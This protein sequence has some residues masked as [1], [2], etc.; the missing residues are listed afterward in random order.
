MNADRLLAL[1][2]RVAE[3]PDAIARLRRFVL[4]LAVRGKLVKQDPADEPASELLKR[5]E[6]EK[7][8]LVQAGKIRKSPPLVPIDHAEQPFAVPNSWEWVSSTYPTLGVSDLGKK[9]KT[10][11][12]LDSG[13]FP[14]VDQG[15]V[16]VRGYC[17]DPSRVIAVS[18]PVVVFGDHTREAKLIDFDFVVGADGVKI[19]QP[20]CVDPYFYHLALQWLPL[21]SRG[22]ARHFKLLKSSCVPLPPLA[23]QRRI[24]AKLDELMTLCDRLEEARAVR[25]DTRDRLTAA[26]LARLSSSNVDDKAFRIHARFAV[27]SLPTLTARADQVTHVRQTILNLAARGKLVEQDT[28]EEAVEISLRAIQSRRNTL[29]KSGTLRRPKPMRPIAKGDAP[30]RIPDTWSWVRVGEIALSFQYGTSSKATRSDK[31]V[32]VLTM[33]NIQ[34]GSIVRTT[35][36]TI[37]ETS[38]EL[39][40]LFLKKHDLLYNRTNSAEL[41]GKTGIYLG[42]EDRLAFASYL[43]RIRL[44]LEH[45]E[46]RYINFVMNAPYFRE[47]QIVPHI[48]KQTGQANV[49][50]STLRNML[51]PLPSLAEQR[52]I[53]A[54][55]DELIAHCDGLEVALNAANGTRS[56]LL[57]AILGAFSASVDGGSRGV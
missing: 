1:Y 55:V 33:S 39:P 8:R 23:E 3:A 11:D 31:G 46:P 42:D 28:T 30:F 34:D 20:V 4:D 22:Y 29:V 25:E 5:I 13:A 38:S 26:S 41:V 49:S 57:Q 7:A 54:K 10:K 21:D 6:A 44:S 40:A 35:E 43:I 2:D 36:K 12:V 15:K 37:P 9:V 14:V 52:R 17:D 56:N 16:T 51:I 50:G 45:T 32:P 47:T 53:V 19:L 27:D 48:K 24:V 18:A